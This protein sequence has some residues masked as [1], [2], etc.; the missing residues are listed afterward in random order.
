M[1]RPGFDPELRRVRADERQGDLRRFL[2]HV[3]ELPGQG[4]PLALVLTRGLDEQDVPTR[5]GHGEA[6]RDARDRGPFGHL[7][8]GEA[9]AAQIAPH[10][11]AVDDDRSHRVA[12]GELRRDLAEGLAQLSL[13]VANARFPRVRRH[14]LAEGIVRDTHFVLSEPVALDLPRH[15]VM[16]SD[17]DLLVLRVPVEPE[18]LHPVEQRSR[19]R[20]GDVARRD[21]QHLRQVEIDVEVVVAEG[22]VL[23]RVEHLEER[24]GGVAAPVGSDLVDLIE[25]HHGVLRPRVLQRAHDPSRQRTDVRPAVAADLGLVVHATEGDADELPSERTRDRLAERRLADTGRSDQ[26]EDRAGSSSALFREPTLR[27]E[28]ADGQVFDDPV[29][30]VAEALVILV[31]DATRV[32][33]VQVVLGAH[34]PGKLGHPI[35]VRADPPVLG[36]LLG[37]S[38]EPAELP[39][40]LL[41]DAVGHPGLRDLGAERLDHV[42]RTVFAELLADRGH[43]LAQDR[44]ALTLLEAVRHLVADLLLHLHLGEG[45]LRPLEDELEPALDVDRLED[46]DL[47]L[48]GEIRRVPRDVRD[49]SGIGQAPEELG[50]GGDAPGLDDALD[51]RAILARERFRP[52][53]RGLVR[54]GLELN[55]RRFA[56]AGD[57]DADRRAGQAAD[58]ER[59]RPAPDLAEVLDLRDR[60][61]ARVAPVEPRHEHEQP[62]V[63]RSGGVDRRPGLGRLQRE[64]HHHARQ[65]HTGGQR[66]QRERQS[67]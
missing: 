13:Q 57:A 65:D 61:D 55:P 11:V 21:E 60:P 8:E 59:L 56:G 7:F 2:H 41:A 29:L 17:R 26:G 20:L 35:E 25:H 34:V 48:E 47:P 44:L 58:H 40:G 31:E 46:L 38:L 9:L 23:R 28:L 24:R 33:D 37:G 18:H 67:V 36:R 45:V 30:H 1:S 52:F 10:V 50:D 3:A 4:Q 14:D 19:D 39:L 42:L 63:V 16:P 22:V 66:E 27:P 54:D 15:Q 6:R 62:V 5:A 49:L 43:L 64:R 51:R 12:R 32:G 53:G